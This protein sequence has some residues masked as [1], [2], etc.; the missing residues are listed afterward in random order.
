MAAVTRHNIVF[1]LIFLGGLPTGHHALHSIAVYVDEGGHNHETAKQNNTEN[2]AL[3]TSFRWSPTTEID[4][5]DAIHTNKNDFDPGLRDGNSKNIG[6]DVLEIGL[7]LNADAPFGSPQKK[8][9]TH[10]YI[11]DRLFVDDTMTEVHTSLEATTSFGDLLDQS[12]QH[13]W[14][15]NTYQDVVE[16][17]PVIS[18]DSVQ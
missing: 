15:L 12:S 13:V 11:G 5:T 2:K 4:H 14:P 9:T 8:Y 17:G 6:T 10:L 3:K 16:I 7:Q 18:V 1:V